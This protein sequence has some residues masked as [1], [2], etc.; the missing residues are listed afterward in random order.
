MQ[1]KSCVFVKAFA[2]VCGCIV[3]VTSVAA[4]HPLVSVGSA[5]ATELAPSLELAQPRCSC[6]IAQGKSVLK[7]LPQNREE[8]QSRTQKRDGPEF[9]LQKRDESEFLPQKHDG[10]K[11]FPHCSRVEGKHSWEAAQPRCSCPIAQ[12]KSGLKSLPKKRAELQS[13]PHSPDALQSSA[14]LQ[15][16]GVGAASAAM[17]LLAFAS[18]AVRPPTPPLTEAS[19]P[20]DAFPGAEGFGRTSRGG[21]GGSVYTVDTLEDDGPGSLREAVEATGPRTVV[22]AV[23]GTIRL[24]SP[25]RIEHDFITIAGQS[26]P[27]QG[28]TLRDQSLIIAANDVVVRYLRARLGN[29]GASEEADAIWIAGGTRVILDH[30]SASW[31]TDETL[32]IAPRRSGVDAPLGDLTVQWSFITESLNQSTHPKGAHGYGSL[33]RGWRGS[34]YSL[35]H[36]LWAHHRARMPRPGNYLERKDDA[37]G[38]LMDFRNNVFYNWGASPRAADGSPAVDAAGY[39]I[40]R[41]SVIA[42]NFINNAYRR[43]PDSQAALAFFE[44]NPGARAF[45]SGNSMD[46]NVAADPWKLVRGGTHSGY[47]LDA[48][49][50]VMQVRTHSADRAYKLVLR[51][52][53]ASFAR[54]AVDERIVADVHDGLG[55]LIDAQSDV[56][57]WPRLRTGSAPIDS[58][59]DGMPDAWEIR[60]G[61]DPQTDDSAH[62]QAN[63]F[64]RLENHLNARVERSVPRE[65]D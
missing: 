40:D 44:T 36:N 39:D 61:S 57:G 35:H 59:R 28:I 49:L 4:R 38:A 65:P 37:V 25:L 60:H 16:A 56:G 64:T 29:E 5:H 62:V 20:L 32:S 30:V 10:L 54:D 55:R 22:F 3:V 31:S 50:T 14:A 1:L 34:R 6:P 12:G 21:R 33:V 45:F 24:R 19:K 8:P 46:G 43:G 11:S 52:A 47:R 23:A 2:V 18:A 27:G 51:D 48:P 7:S 58:D 13:L 26:A 41:D 53:G 15:I 63:G 9:V 42:Y 17:P